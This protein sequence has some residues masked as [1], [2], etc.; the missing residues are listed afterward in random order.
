MSASEGRNSRPA[1]RQVALFLFFV[2]KLE[3]FADF[4]DF[5]V[6][7]DELAFENDCTANQDEN[8]HQ[9]HYHAEAHF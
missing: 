9:G 7:Q 4:F 6:S 3:F 8:W 1:I 2:A 5:A